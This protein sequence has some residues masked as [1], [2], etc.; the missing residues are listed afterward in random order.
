MNKLP[1]GTVLKNG[2]TV[3]AR[4][5]VTTKVATEYKSH[6]VAICVRGGATIDKNYI[7][8]TIYSSDNGLESR[9]EHYCFHLKEALEIYSKI[10]TVRLKKPA[11]N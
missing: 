6:W 7:V 1:L 2:M 8:C 11:V 3:V 9:D 5:A 10:E 4:M